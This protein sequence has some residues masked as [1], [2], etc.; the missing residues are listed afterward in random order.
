MKIN[1]NELLVKMKNIIF[2]DGD[3]RPV[4]VGPKLADTDVLEFKN[5]SKWANEHWGLYRGFTSLIKESEETVIIDLGCGCGFCTINLS[6]MFKQSLLLGY[7]IDDKSISFTNRYNKNE[8]IKYYTENIL[9]T[10]LPKSDYIF[11]IETLE[12][13]KHSEH[14][15]LIDKCLNSLKTNGLLFISTP[16]ENNYSNEEKGHIGILTPNFFNDFKEKYNK[17]I[18][19]VKYFDNKK[20]LGDADKFTTDKPSSHFKI[21]LKK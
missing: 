9:N 16:N 19:E 20:L 12:H 15:G 21:I 13:I 11:L 1:D 4:W 5:Y 7:D 17:N 14:Y 10:E 8:K 18:V 3:V 6:D 2:H